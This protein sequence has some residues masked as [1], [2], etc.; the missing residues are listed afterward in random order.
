MEMQFLRWIS[1]IIV[2]IGREWDDPVARIDQ[3]H[4]LRNRRPTPLPPERPG[5]RIS[6]HD[7]GNLLAEAAL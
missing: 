3:R 1:M 7:A 5:N 6:A 2:P 4:N